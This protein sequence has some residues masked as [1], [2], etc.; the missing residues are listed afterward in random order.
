MFIFWRS[1]L[2]SFVEVTFDEW[3]AGSYLVDRGRVPYDSV[4]ATVLKND[5]SVANRNR[6]QE[7]A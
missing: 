6:E 7:N 5:E 1:L 3:L 4:E 2:F